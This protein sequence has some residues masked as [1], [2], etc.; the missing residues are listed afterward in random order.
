MNPLTKI[1]L[2]IFIESLILI[3]S[4]Y[5]L[6]SS[7][8]DIF[9]DKIREIVEVIDLNYIKDIDYDAMLNRTVETLLQSLDP[10]AQYYSS[11]NQ[12]EKFISLQEGNRSRIGIEFSYETLPN[13]SKI[14]ALKIISILENS[15]A[16]QAMLEIGDIIVAI[17]DKNIEN[18]VN[19]LDITKEL[20]KGGVGTK[21]SLLVKKKKNNLVKLELKKELEKELTVNGKIEYT[22]NGGISYLKISHFNKKTF[23]EVKKFIKEQE[24]KLKS[25]KKKMLALI[26]DLRDNPGGLL[27]QAVAISEFF[28]TKGIIVKIKSRY[29]EKI[30]KVDE[31]SEKF[32]NIPIIILINSASASASEIIAAALQ[33]NKRALIIGTTSFGKAT[34]QKLLN[35]NQNSAIK[36]TTSLYY[37]PNGKSID[38]HGIEPD[39]FVENNKIQK[40]DDR[41]AHLS[42]PN[43]ENVKDIVDDFPNFTHKIDYQ[44]NKALDMILSILF[45]GKN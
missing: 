24:N 45:L 34:V 29:E 2:I 35:V 23:L 12:I 16:A 21:I 44:Y 7:K 27:E 15:L 43:K 3:N 28:L 37:T 20:Q 9:C 31:K 5:L 39:I 25:Q 6:A 1:F 11:E 4:P 41:V 22:K 26:L 40:D 17:N 18:F 10:F 13:S 38:G 30:Y 36:I 8:K 14:N 33:D 32:P 42:F 19:T